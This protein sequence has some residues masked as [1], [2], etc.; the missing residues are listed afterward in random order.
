[1]EEK[2]TN[3]ERPLSYLIVRRGSGR[4]DESSTDHRTKG[5]LQKS[6]SN[7]EYHIQSFEVH[8]V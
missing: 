8:A 1:M 2:D 5:R 3:L 7:S 4:Q 6:L